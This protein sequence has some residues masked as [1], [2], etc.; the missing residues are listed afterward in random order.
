MAISISRLNMLAEDLG[1]CGDSFLKGTGVALIM[2]TKRA[3]RSKEDQAIDDA[4]YVDELQ[5]VNQKAKHYTMAL[6]DMQNMLSEP[7]ESERVYIEEALH[8][9]HYVIEQELKLYD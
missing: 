8:D 1:I 3:V 6:F 7:F 5:E 4:E 9:L 2:K